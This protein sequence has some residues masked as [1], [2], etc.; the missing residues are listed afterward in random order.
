MKSPRYILEGARGRQ[1]G[2]AA[3][4]ATVSVG[5]GSCGTVSILGFLGP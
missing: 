5:R 4:G 1:E 3:R 2:G